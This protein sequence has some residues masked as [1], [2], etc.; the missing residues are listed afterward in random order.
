MAQSEKSAMSLHQAVAA[1]LLAVL[2]VGA[3]IAGTNA[4]SIKELLREGLP[5]VSPPLLAVSDAEFAFTV[6]IRRYSRTPRGGSAPSE[7]VSEDMRRFFEMRGLQLKVTI[8]EVA[9][10]DAAGP[11]PVVQM[12]LKIRVEPASSDMVNAGVSRGTR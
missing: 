8:G 10:G 9:T 5:V 12:T 7:A 2:Q 11:R 6:R 1:P 4:D 3:R